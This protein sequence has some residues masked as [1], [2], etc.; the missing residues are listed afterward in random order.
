[1][2]IL[3]D[4]HI[5]VTDFKIYEDNMSTIKSAVLPSQKRLKHVDIAFHHVQDLIMSKILVVEHINSGDQ[6][7]DLLTKPSKL[8]LHMM[9]INL[10]GG[11]KEV[12]LS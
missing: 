6:L 2:K 10:R 1:M 11:V 3:K 12:T 8:N 7:A 5:E 9:K 4:L